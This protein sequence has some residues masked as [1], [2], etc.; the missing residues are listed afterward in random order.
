MMSAEQNFKSSQPIRIPRP[1]E[2]MDSLNDDLFTSV[3]D[4]R[5]M[6][7]ARFQNRKG[8]SISSLTKFKN[9]GSASTSAAGNSNKNTENQFDE[10]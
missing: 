1:Q 7:T 10:S 2:S 5:I 3:L 6:E 8:R 4:Q 9:G